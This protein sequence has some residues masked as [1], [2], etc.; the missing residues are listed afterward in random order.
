VIVNALARL[1]FCTADGK[2]EFR[3]KR[4]AAFAPPGYK[5]WFEHADRASADHVVVC[6]HWSTQQLML[7]PSVLML[8]SGCLWGGALTAVRLEDRRVFQV[9]STRPAVPAPFG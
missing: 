5:A 1:R 7:T 2:M 9:P 4:G 3:E 6:G 8:D